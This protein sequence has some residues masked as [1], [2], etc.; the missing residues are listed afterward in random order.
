MRRGAAGP[1][2]RRRPRLRPCPPRRP[3]RPDEGARQGAPRSAGPG[4]ALATGF[5]PSGISTFVTLSTSACDRFRSSQLEPSDLP[6]DVLP[7]TVFE[8]AQDLGPLGRWW[9]RD[10]FRKATFK[11][12]PPLQT[13]PGARRLERAET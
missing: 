4:D 5:K 6:P 10:E 12:R 9:L 3:P 13:F 2:R 7:E 8:K 1:K 11:P